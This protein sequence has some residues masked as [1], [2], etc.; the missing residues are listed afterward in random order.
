VTGPNLAAHRASSG[1]L[2]AGIR[3]ERIQVEEAICGLSGRCT[4]EAAA[5]LSRC[6]DLAQEEK[7]SL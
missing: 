4:E 5:G 7:V 1:D 3:A 6:Q 2:G